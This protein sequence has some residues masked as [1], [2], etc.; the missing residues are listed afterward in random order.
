MQSVRWAAKIEP[1]RSSNWRRSPPRHAPLK[2]VQEPSAASRVVRSKVEHSHG[3]QVELG[4]VRSAQLRSGLRNTRWY[5]WLKVTL[6]NEF[7][8]HQLMVL[9]Y[10]SKGQQQ[11]GW[12]IRGLESD[13]IGESGRRLDRLWSV[14][15]N[16]ISIN[17]LAFKFQLI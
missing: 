12:P 1:R 10:S 13:I 3:S 9:Y 7:S 11:D 6:W 4:Q 16:G 15:T 2:G 17:Q 8:W 5:C 14:Q